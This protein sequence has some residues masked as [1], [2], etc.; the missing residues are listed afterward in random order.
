MITVCILNKTFNFAENV[1]SEWT[2]DVD[3]RIYKGIHIGMERGFI[4]VNDPIVI[5]T[6]W[7]PGSGSTNTMRIINAVEMTDKDMLAPIT[8]ITSVPSF[9]KIEAGE[10]ETPS[11][12][13]SS[14]QGDG[15]N[16][17]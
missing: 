14:I 4:K 15:I 7:K 9:N 13:Q 2:V 10:M 11:S 12:S 8:G 17:Y 6:G 16:F 1:M 3:R 5:V